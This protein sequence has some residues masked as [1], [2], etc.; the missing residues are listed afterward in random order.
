MITHLIAVFAICVAVVALM[1]AWI[2]TWF[3]ARFDA[4]DKAFVALAVLIL[5]GVALAALSV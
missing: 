3:G 4:R 5:A 1:A 2:S